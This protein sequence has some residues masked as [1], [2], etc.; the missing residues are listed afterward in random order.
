[1]TR[2]ELK[3]MFFNMGPRVEPEV[4]EVIVWPEYG[5]VE[6]MSDGPDGYNS[7]KTNQG[8]KALKYA[9]DKMRKEKYKE[10]KLVIK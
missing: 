2:E 9:K 10:Y 8:D 7:F 3:T 6:I 4:K 1:M 5:H